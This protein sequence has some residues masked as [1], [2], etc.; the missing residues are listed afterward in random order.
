MPSGI[1][2]TTVQEISPPAVYLSPDGP[3]RVPLDS[4]LRHDIRALLRR[5]ERNIVLDLARVSEIDAAGVG[6]LV[7]AY[8]I[9]TAA[10]G[11]LRIV[12]TISWVREILDRVGLFETLSENASSQAGSINPQ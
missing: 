6:Q 9:A 11:T 5:G 7:R 1:A 4:A 10:N 12:Q 8:N 2:M 3:L